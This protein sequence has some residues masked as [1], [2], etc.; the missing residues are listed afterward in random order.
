MAVPTNGEHRQQRFGQSVLGRQNSG[1][2]PRDKNWRRREPATKGPAQ[3]KAVLASGCPTREEARGTTV[4]GNA[5]GHGVAQKPR[6]RRPN[7]IEEKVEQ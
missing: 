7:S 1:R 2:Y 4:S 6:L 3:S 5:Q